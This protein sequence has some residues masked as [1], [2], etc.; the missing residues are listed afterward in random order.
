MSLKKQPNS[1]LLNLFVDVHWPLVLT[2][3]LTLVIIPQLNATF[4]SSNAAR[5]PFV[6]KIKNKKAFGTRTSHFLFE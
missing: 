6:T 3:V 2:P 1:T 5:G 4:V